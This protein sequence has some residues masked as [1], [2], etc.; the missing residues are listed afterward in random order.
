MLKGHFPEDRAE[1][2][3]ELQR[4]CAEVYT[5]IFWKK[6]N[7]QF[8]ED[9]RNAEITVDPVL[10]ARSKLSE[11]KVNGPEDAIVREII[12]RSPMEKIYTKTKCFQ[13]RFLGR[14]GS[15]RSWKV[16]KQVFL[17]KPD[18]VPTKGIRSYR[19]MAL[20]SVMSKWYA[21]CI[22]SRLE[23]EKEPEKWKKLHIGALDGVSCHHLQ[24]KMT[25]VIQKHWEWQEGRNPVM[26]HGTV[27][28]PT[29]YLASSDIKTAFDEAR[30][31]HVA[32]IS[33]T[34]TRHTDGSLRLLREILGLS[35]KAMF[36]C[37][38]SSF[39]FNRCLRQE[40]VE[41]PR[42]WQKMATQILANVE[43]EWMKQRKG[44]LLDIEAEGEVHQI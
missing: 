17:R 24:V 9:G 10:Q 22:L 23:K 15:P 19:A 39:A 13:E 16:V 34:V 37:V 3:K 29:L 6:G 1:W 14:M 12:K 27:V 30:P 8:T 5:D 31:K 26:K 18:A 35:G 33:W 4:H 41:A 38:E 28:R 44:V 42:L 11:N 36:E 20:T 40:S 43:E 25:S 21:S 32:K 7:Q 2:Q